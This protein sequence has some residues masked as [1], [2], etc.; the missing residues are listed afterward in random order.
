MKLVIAT[1]HRTDR[2]IAFPRSSERGPIEAYTSPPEDTVAK[3]FRAHRS[4]A[5]LKLLPM[6]L[7]MLLVMHF[8]A[9]RSA[10]PLK[11]R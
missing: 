4:A 2:M 7:L 10:A 6:L 11:R 8:R 9:H 1:L 3:D 5:P